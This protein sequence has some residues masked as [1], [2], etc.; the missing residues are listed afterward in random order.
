M[1]VQLVPFCWGSWIIWA[2]LVL[3]AIL[4]LLRVLVFQLLMDWSMVFA[5]DLAHAW[6]GFHS[7]KILLRCDRAMYEL[8]FG[9]SA[10]DMTWLINIAP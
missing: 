9:G 3:Q 1:E 5:M 10:N 4:F 2:M 6:I 8:R 7:V